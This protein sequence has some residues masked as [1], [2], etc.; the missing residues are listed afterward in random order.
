MPLEPAAV[1]GGSLAAGEPAGAEQGEAS[2]AWGAVGQRRGHT[3]RL[4]SCM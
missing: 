4:S 3:C 1:G 2:R